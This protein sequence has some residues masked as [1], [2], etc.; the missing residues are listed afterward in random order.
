[1]E[2]QPQNPEFRINSETF[3]HVFGI[4][5][6]IRVYWRACILSLIWPFSRVSF[7]SLIYIQNVIWHKIAIIN[8]SYSQYLTLIMKAGFMCR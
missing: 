4:C 2:N 1:M 6:L 5:Q 8:D 3:T 7:L